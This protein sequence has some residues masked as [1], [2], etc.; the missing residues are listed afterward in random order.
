MELRHRFSVPAPTDRTWAIFDDIGAVAGC[1][2]GATIEA[3]AGDRCEGAVTIKLGPIALQY[4]GTATYV[5]RVEAERRIAIRATGRDRRGQGTADATL[6]VILAPEGEATLVEVTTDLAITGRPAQFGRGMI[7]DVSDRYLAKFVTALSERLQPAPERPPGA[8]GAPAP[9]GVD[10]A[11]LA[12]GGVV[13][14]H[15]GALAA[16]GLALA[17]VALLRRAIARGTG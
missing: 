4:A 1:F 16:A 15:A 8:G 10:V 13:R 6:D 12:L 9:G 2:P 7:E 11:A 3:A 14:R 5:E 17:M